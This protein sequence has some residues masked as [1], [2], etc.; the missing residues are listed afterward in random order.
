MKTCLCCGQAKEDSEFGVL[1]GTLRSTCNPCRR[2]DAADRYKKNPGKVKARVKKYCS[3]PEGKKVHNAAVQRSRE[4]YPDRE[5]C[6]EYFDGAVA[7]GNV[8]KF[9]CFVCGEHAEGHHP[10]YSQP[11]SVVWLCKKHHRE[12]HGGR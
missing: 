10:D 6:R 1:R 8:Q 11:L 5:K 12:V 3:T 2:K 7:S 9:P 4:K